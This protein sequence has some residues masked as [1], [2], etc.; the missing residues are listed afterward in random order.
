MRDKAHA[1]RVVMAEPIADFSALLAGELRFNDVDNRPGR[2]AR[3]FDLF[4][5]WAGDET[6]GRWASHDQAP[7]W[8][9]VA[10]AAHLDPDRLDWQSLKLMDAARA[11]VKRTIVEYFA[12]CLRIGCAGIESGRLPADRRD[13][14]ETSVV[15]RVHFGLYFEAQGRKLPI[16][17]AMLSRV[18]AREATTGATP[19]LSV[20]GGRSGSTGS[21]GESTMAAASNEPAQS[22]RKRRRQAAPVNVPADAQQLTVEQVSVLIGLSRAT[23]YRM[24]KAGTFPLP[25]PQGSSSAVRWARVDVDRWMLD[26]REGRGPRPSSRRR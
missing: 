11:D 5:R 25:I 26:Q 22:G 10:L 4:V 6:W 15:R 1:E 18:A 3:V 21:N 23:V 12:G 13:P 19:S 24:V 8:Q 2:E 14:I 7:L 17:F 20:V 9:W 16:R